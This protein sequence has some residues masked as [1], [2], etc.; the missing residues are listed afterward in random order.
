MQGNKTHEQFQRTVERKPDVVKPGEAEP[1]APDTLA[2]SA[3]APSHPQA[4]QS[5]MAVSRQGMHQESRHN[6]HNDPGQGGGE[7]QKHSPA[8]E[9]R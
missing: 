5:E 8:E 6:K 1:P 9:G 7:P 2:S 3:Q 4:R